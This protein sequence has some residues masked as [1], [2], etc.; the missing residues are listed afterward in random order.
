MSFTEVVALLKIIILSPEV[1]I[2]SIILALYM[3]LVLYVVRY[4]KKTFRAK[5]P[6]RHVIAKT[7]KAISTDADDEDDRERDEDDE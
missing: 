3:N 4:R 1:L 2:I 6:W 7:A 5:K